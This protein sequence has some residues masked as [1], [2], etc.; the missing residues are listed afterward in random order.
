MKCGG[1]GGGGWSH[2]FVYECNLIPLVTEGC[3]QNFI[4]QVQHLQMS[5]SLIGEFRWGHSCSSSSCCHA[6]V[7]STLVM[8][9]AEPDIDLTC[10][11]NH[12]I[13]LLLAVFQASG[14][15]ID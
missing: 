9:Y 5:Q 15:L 11:K 10:D 8:R 14:F 6:K 13:V 12:P 4:T 2:K 1:Q 3:M 7:K